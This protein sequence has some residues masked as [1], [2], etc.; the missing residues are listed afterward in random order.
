MSRTQLRDRIVEILRSPGARPMNKSELIRALELPASAR[1]LLRKELAALENQGKI[2]AGKKG[3]YELSSAQPDQLRGSIK[4]TPKGHAWFFPD[5]GDPDNLATGH[6][7]EELSRVHVP[8]RDTGT[9]LDGDRVLVTVL[10]PKI[11]PRDFRRQRR[12][13]EPETEPEWRARV[14]KV[15]TRRSGKLVG[16]F[17][18][19]AKLGWI[20]CDDPA[21]N[22]NVELIGDTT[23]RPGQLVVARVEQWQN[24]TPYARI[25][26]VLGWPDDAGVDILAIIHKNG[27]RQSFPDDVL[28]EA[29]AF[30]DEVD[31]AETTHREDWRN[32]LV[33]TID[34]ADAKDHDDAIWVEK[35][36][37]GWQLAVHIADVSHYV[38]PRTELDKEAAERGNSTYLVDRVI[39]MLPVELS[40]GLCSLKP[41]VDRFTKCAVLEINRQGKVIGSRF[42]N[43]IIHSQAKLS[44]EQAQTIL[45]GGKA[46][47][48][49]VKGLAPMVREAWAMASKMRS[50]RFAEGALDL[51]MPEIRVRLDDQGKATRIENVIHTESHQLIEECML[52]ANESVARI[53]KIRQKPTIYRIHEEPDS[54]RLL[55][56]GETAKAFGYSFGDLT[57][58]DHIQKLLDAAK[59]QPDEHAIKIGLLKSLKRAAYSPDPLGHYG[60]SKT[61]YCHFTSPIRRYADLVVHRSLQ[62]FLDN[63][64]QQPD[65]TPRQT[66]LHELARH[67]SD[68]E[69]ASADAENESKNLKLLEYLEHTTQLPEPVHFEGLITEVRPMGLMVEATGI[70]TRGLVKREDLGPGWTIEA[71]FDRA[72]SRD[73][74]RLL[75]GQ[76]VQLEVARI[77]RDRKFVDFRIVGEGPGETTSDARR[78]RR[79]TG[80]GFTS[81]RAEKSH[82]EKSPKRG[83]P[84]N[85]AKSTAGKPSKRPKKL[86]HKR[87]RK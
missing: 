55:D 13:P 59:G 75:M 38:K 15:L 27:I 7:L 2:A 87:R 72:V 36:E 30:G 79:S 69:R 82:T 77:D 32:R 84:K 56:Y 54:G 66:E 76:R 33:I 83:K 85:P 50:R 31:P 57:N 74:R 12:S 46:P 25:I 19:K 26:E 11:S 20:E 34:P 18:Q 81:P 17:R 48:G 29:R 67:I 71:R 52:A 53:L 51:E 70:S 3:R 42:C 73:G 4:F 43:A 78:P 37:N 61:D 39:P 40:N 65:K 14:E 5:A 21:I 86:N 62:P 60:L 41:D 1:P 80:K 22:G 16:I 8:R 23:A 28:A 49:S 47:K 64:P 63:P 9:A 45:D 58:K 10:R 6:D 24:D 68:T 44:Y 35:T